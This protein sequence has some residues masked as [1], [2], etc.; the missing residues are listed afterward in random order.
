MHCFTVSDL[1]PALQSRI[2]EEELRLAGVAAGSYNYR[3]E[4][5]T[6][7]ISLWHDW[8][9][10]E[11]HKPVYRVQTMTSKKIGWISLG[12]VLSHDEKEKRQ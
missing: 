9:N 10:R 3:R 4:E 1:S 12:Q 2:F 6:G 11:A 5:E 7:L 8:Q